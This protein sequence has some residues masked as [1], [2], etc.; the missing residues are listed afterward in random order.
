VL[1]FGF[2]AFLIG[3]LRRTITRLESRTRGLALKVEEMEK[4]RKG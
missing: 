4:G 1:A 3:M 2:L